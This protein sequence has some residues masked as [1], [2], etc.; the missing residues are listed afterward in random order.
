[1]SDYRKGIVYIQN[2]RAGFIEETE[3]GFLFMYDDQYVDSNEAVPVS[4]TMPLQKEPYLSKLIA[5]EYYNAI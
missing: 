5:S 4:I 3:G 2:T 1:M